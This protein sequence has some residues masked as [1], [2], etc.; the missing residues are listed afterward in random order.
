[1]NKPGVINTLDWKQ[2][3]PRP[4]VGDEIEV[5]DILLSLGVIDVKHAMG[6]ELGFECSGVLHQLCPDA[7]MF[8][9]GE[10][11]I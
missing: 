5:E 7:K 3:D 1:M 11:V 4:L 9:R 10:T 2:I 6:W 8:Q